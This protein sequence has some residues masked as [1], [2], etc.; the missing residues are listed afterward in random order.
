MKAINLG[1]FGI[2]GI[3]GRGMAHGRN[4]AGKPGDE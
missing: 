1:I 2:F 3:G 4:I